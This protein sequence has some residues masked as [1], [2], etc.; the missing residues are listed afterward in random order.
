MQDGA[1]P[2]DAVVPQVAI[3]RAGGNAD[4]V[5]GLMAAA[6][7]LSGD[8]DVSEEVRGI[9]KLACLWIGTMCAVRPISALQEDFE[10]TFEEDDVNSPAHQIH[11]AVAKPAT[12]TA[13]ALPS[14]DSGS[15]SPEP[16]VTTV[17]VQG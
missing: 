14:S 4:T 5:A 2:G 7:K 15:N 12:A 6:K 16:N 1:S 10:E 11:Q 13:A 17:K 9:A 8:L 3:K